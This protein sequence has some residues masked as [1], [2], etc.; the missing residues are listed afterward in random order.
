MWRKQWGM[1]GKEMAL[2]ALK[3][4][5]APSLI[6][7]NQYTIK[8]EK[9]ITTFYLKSVLLVNKLRKKK[10]TIFSGQR[11]IAKEKMDDFRN[12]SIKTASV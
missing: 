5:S 7:W 3:R 1:K 10:K 8:L 9:N 12:E 2:A 11:H 4:E 6:F